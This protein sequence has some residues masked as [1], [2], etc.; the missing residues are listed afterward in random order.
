MLGVAMFLHVFVLLIF[1]FFEKY[2]IISPPIN[3]ER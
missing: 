3:L 1:F 2:F